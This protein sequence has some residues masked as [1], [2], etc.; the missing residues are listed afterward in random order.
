MKGLG[1]ATVTT[2]SAPVTARRR[3][4][5]S[6]VQFRSSVLLGGIELGAVLVMYL[7]WQGTPAIHGLG[8]WLTNAGR[9]T[10]LLG[11]YAAAVLLL[12]M[13]RVPAIEHGVGADRL[14]RWHS[15]GGRYTVLL[16]SAHTLLIIWGYAVTAHTS[17]T[18]QTTD[19]LFSYPDVLMATAALLI[20]FAVGVVSAR[21]ARSRLRYET[22]YY[23]HLYTYLAI[24]LAFSHQFATGADFV[25]NFAARALW[26]SMYVVIASLLAW[27]RVLVP[28]RA[29]LRHRVRVVQ[30]RREA[31]GMISILM[32][33]HHLDELRAQ[34]GQFF[35]WRFLTRDGWWQSHPFSLSAPVRAPWLRIT[36]KD[37]GDHSHELQRVRPG[38][39]VF[40]EGPY[41]AFTAAQQRTDRVLLIAGGVGIAPL[42]ALFETVS[43]CAGGVTLIYRVSREDELIFRPELDAIAAAR[44]GTVHYLVGNRGGPRDP[45]V[46]RRLRSLVPA[47]AHTDVFL[48]GSAGFSTAATASLKRCGVPASLIHT[49]HFAF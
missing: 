26:S 25:D 32:T 37:F 46:G 44:G 10:G 49:E 14:A 38:T 13:A 11:G 21:A 19:L 29:T 30:V 16:L 8:D 1:M 2:Q 33:G 34:S 18:S 24:A 43:A 45:F 28:I 4:R 22:W 7:W 40:L 39:T 47:L 23:I 48:C 27:Y 3:F 36:V 5:R 41:G 9:I 31:P 15:F 42:R 6:H 12:L 35:R 17:L 20:L